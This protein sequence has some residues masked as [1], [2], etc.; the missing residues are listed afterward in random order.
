MS[1]GHAGHGPDRFEQIYRAGGAPW[2][3]GR[4][5]R[6]IVRLHEAG[7]LRG[8]VLDVGCGTGENALWLAAQGRSVTGVDG[9]PTAVERAR[10][11]AAE[12]GL[13]VPFLV[14]DALH[15]EKLRR[16]WETVIDCGLFHTLDPEERR[17]Y[18]HSLTEVLSPGGVL[19]VLCFSDAEPEGPG[20]HR[21]PEYD[22]RATFRS[23]FAPV[24]CQPAVLET[25]RP[26]GDARAWLA[27]FMRV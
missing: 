12:R 22:L 14:A 2:D 4:P 13:A 21:L 27:T 18:A 7:E 25:L 1:D 23:L 5:Q 3:I 11:K 16:R 6:E 20:P 9:S 8:T 26:E 10:A 15:L 24:R 17:P 19:H